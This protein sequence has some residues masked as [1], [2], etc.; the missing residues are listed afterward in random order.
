[1]NCFFFFHFSFN[2]SVY[3][4][5]FLYLTEICVLLGS[6]LWTMDL[7]RTPALSPSRTMKG[8]VWDPIMQDHY[9]LLGALGDSSRSSSRSSM[10]M[11][12]GA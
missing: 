4:C 5:L 6:L 11:I 12:Y 1:M 3:F 7:V 2:K 10:G 9:V 8:L